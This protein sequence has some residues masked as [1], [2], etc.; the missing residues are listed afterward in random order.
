MLAF[1]CLYKMIAIEQNR[2]VLMTLLLSFKK[3]KRYAHNRIE[4]FS[5]LSCYTR[6][7]KRTRHKPFY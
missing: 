6:Y 1:I 3:E 7:Y 5:L 4:K 2:G